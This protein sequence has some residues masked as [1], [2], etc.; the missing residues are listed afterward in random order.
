MMS[1]RV[2]GADELRC[3]ADAVYGEARGEGFDSQAYVVAVILNRVRDPRW[4]DTVCDVVYQRGQFH[5]VQLAID[6]TSAQYLATSEK[7]F[8][9][10]ERATSAHKSRYYWFYA[11]DLVSRRPKWDTGCGKLVGGHW[12]VRECFNKLV[13]ASK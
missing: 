13:L 2:A 11:P 4:P 9:L 5:G 6:R 12:Y 8:R 3:L 10:V 7:L 1:P